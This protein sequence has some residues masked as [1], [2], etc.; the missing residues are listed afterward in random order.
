VEHKPTVL[1]AVKGEDTFEALSEVV[2]MFVPVKHRSNC[3]DDFPVLKGRR[4]YGLHEG[5]GKA[6]GLGH[7][8]LS[9]HNLMVLIDTIL[10][11]D[12][13]DVQGI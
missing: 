2:L 3:D 6:G 10:G 1:E 7:A 11:S 9:C 5:L 13:K 12:L 8:E 4:L